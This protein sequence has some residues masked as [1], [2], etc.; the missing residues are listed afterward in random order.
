MNKALN[1]D[2]INSHFRSWRVAYAYV[3][4]GKNTNNGWLRLLPKWNTNNG[5]K[6][7]Y[8]YGVWLF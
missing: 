3:V 2:K 4:G 6:T 8:K 5:T 7:S 1:T